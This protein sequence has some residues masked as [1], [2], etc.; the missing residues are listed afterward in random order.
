[1]NLDN[2]I[3]RLELDI[4]IIVETIKDCVLTPA[5]K[6]DLWGEQEKLE[7]KLNECLMDQGVE[8]NT[9]DW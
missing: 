6:Q 2:Q 4:S 1:M 9:W 3:A 5:E 8:I 7:S